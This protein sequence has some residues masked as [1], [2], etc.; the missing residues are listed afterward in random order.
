ML[1][2][3]HSIVVKVWKNVGN[4]VTE[5]CAL[6]I[7]LRFSTADLCSFVISSKPPHAMGLKLKAV[8]TEPAQ[9]ETRV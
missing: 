5:L 6:F 4:A 7:I 2:S 1:L 9:S 8:I 3:F